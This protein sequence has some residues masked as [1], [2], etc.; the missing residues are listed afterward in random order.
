MIDKVFIFK[1][2]YGK[3]YGV[4]LVFFGDVRELVVVFFCWFLIDVFNIYKYI[5]FEGV[6]VNFIVIWVVIVGLGDY[7]GVVV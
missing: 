4:E 3:V 5:E 6:G 7:V 2:M 1:V